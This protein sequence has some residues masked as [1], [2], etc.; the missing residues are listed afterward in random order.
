MDGN[1]SHGSSNTYA[2]SDHV[3]PSDTSRA[4]QEDVDAL[5]VAINNKVLYRTSV[6]VLATTGTIVSVS[7]EAITSDHVLAE[8]VFSNPS[9][10]T[11]DLVWT[12][13]S[14]SLTISGTCTTA[15]TANI[16]LIKK[17]N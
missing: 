2:R 7:N 16:V 8:C 4:S 11:T 9:Y 3:H 5:Q 12:T 14:E 17:D 10:I 15:T 1:A 13:A 6:P